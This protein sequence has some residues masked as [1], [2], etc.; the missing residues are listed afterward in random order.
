MSGPDVVGWGGE[1]PAGPR[2]PRWSGWPERVRHA[3]A[4]ARRRRW[5]GLAGTVL[6]GLAAAVLA[7]RAGADPEAPPPPQPTRTFDLGSPVQFVSEVAFGPATAYALVGACVGPEET[8]SC[9]YRVLQRALTRP[10]WTVT[11]VRTG[12]VAGAA[13]LPR[14]FVAGDRL[15]VVDQPTVGNVLTSPDGG[16]TMTVQGLSA[17]P[18]VPAALRGDIV[19]LGLCE[20]CLDRLTVLEPRTGRLRPLATQPPLG[21]SV[22]VR[23]FADSA[24]AL[25]ALG[26]SGTGLVSSVSLDGG[27]T[28]RTLPLRGGGPGAAEATALAPDGRRGAWLLVSRDADPHTTNEFSELWRVGDPTRP[29]AGWQLVTPARRPRSVDGL[30]VSAGTALIQDEAGQLLRLEPGGVLRAL[31]PIQVDGVP[32]GPDVVVAGPGRLLLAIANR[33]EGTG[34]PR[35]LLSRD[36]G[37]SWQLEELPP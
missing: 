20:S 33:P 17:A 3:S 6:V 4:A 24:G 16:R 8:R 7:F 5:S 10:G 9:R 21:P 22:G 18:P 12:A 29:G 23:A 35:V 15:T 25:W 32:R 31:P 27:R 19:D 34:P 26:D 2:P 13:G 1:E 28:W 11:A 36:G 14:L 30:L 37:R